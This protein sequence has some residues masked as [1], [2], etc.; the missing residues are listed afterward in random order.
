MSTE[1]EGKKK[2]VE[3]TEE[4]IKEKEMLDI[5]EDDDE[6]EEFEQYNLAGK[7]EDIDEVKQ[8]YCLGAYDF[9]WK[10]EGRKFTH[11]NRKEEWEDEEEEED[12]AAEL[13]K[14]LHK[15]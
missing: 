5:L 15:A 8:W 12:F 2:P 9:F 11:T 4:E 13:R 14:Q 10:T 6:F 3:Q 1:K 7:M